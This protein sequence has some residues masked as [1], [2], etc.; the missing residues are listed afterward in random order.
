[1]TAALECLPPNITARIS[2]EGTDGCWLWTGGK[3]P[4]GYGRVFDKGAGALRQAHRLVYERLVGPIPEGLQLDH[5]CRVR[6]CVNPEHLEPVTARENT[7]R[8]DTGPGRNAR[9]THCMR[10][11]EFTPENT[12]IRPNGSRMCRTCRALRRRH[13][14]AAARR[15]M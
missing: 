10:G 9:K 4:N 15:R 11:H 3:N 6:N 14:R 2:A 1:M 8:G 7:I 5:L 13:E 12:R